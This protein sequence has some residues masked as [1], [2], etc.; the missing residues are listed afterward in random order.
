[1]ANMSMWTFL[2]AMCLVASLSMA[3]AEA[4]NYEDV[5]NVEYG[6]NYTNEISEDLKEGG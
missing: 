2:Q 1:M 4:E 6:P 3:M 5:V